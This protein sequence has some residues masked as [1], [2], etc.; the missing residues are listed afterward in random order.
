MAFV[1]C[2]CTIMID[3]KSEIRVRRVSD[4][5]FVDILEIKYQN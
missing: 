3:E 1:F 5:K 4:I 2:A